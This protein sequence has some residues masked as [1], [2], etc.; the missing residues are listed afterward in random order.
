MPSAITIQPENNETFSFNLFRKS[1][2][3]IFIRWNKPEQGTFCREKIK[4]QCHYRDFARPAT[5]L[6]DDGKPSAL[7]LFRCRKIGNQV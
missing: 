7:S 3:G 5:N 6:I 1:H 2:H 4:V